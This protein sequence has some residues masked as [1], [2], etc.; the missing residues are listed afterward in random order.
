MTLWSSQRDLRGCSLRHLLLQSWSPVLPVHRGYTLRPARCHC[1]FCLRGYTHRCRPFLQGYILARGLGPLQGYILARCLGP[2][3]DYNLDHGQDCP[4]GYNRLHLGLSH[5]LQVL[6]LLR[7][8]G[9]TL[10]HRYYPQ[11]CILLHRYYPQDY[12]LLHH[13]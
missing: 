4:Q 1:S 5:D 9:Y 12:T 3:Q 13:G 8:Q 7:L 10:L 11:G 6:S 2:L